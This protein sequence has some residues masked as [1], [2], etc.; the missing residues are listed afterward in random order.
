M[1]QQAVQDNQNVSFPGR[2]S[3]QRQIRPGIQ[4]E[5]KVVVSC[6][7]SQLGSA[8]ESIKLF[9][10]NGDS[11]EISV[12]NEFVSSAIKALNCEDVSLNF[13]GAMKSFT[14]SNKN[15]PNIIQLL[16]P[17]RTY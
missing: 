3:V 14:I 17:I 7:S 1:E 11:L 4:S 2:K 10:Y 12:N 15:D 16:T 6:R 13:N 9:K 8:E 5:N